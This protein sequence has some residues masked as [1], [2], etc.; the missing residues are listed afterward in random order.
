MPIFSLVRQH[1]DDFLTELSESLRSG[2]YE[3]D[4]LLSFGIPKGTSGEVRTLHIPSIRDRVVER[5]VVNAITHRADLA[6]SPCSFAYRT[7]IGT[8]DAVDHLA[9]LRDA[10][11]RYV[12]RTDIEDYFPNLSIEDALAALS[13]IAGC[14]R[15]IDLIRLIARP[16]RARGER[17]TRNRGIAQGSC[18]SPLLANLALTDVDRAMGDAGYGYARFADDIV[19]CSPHEPDLLEALELLDSLLTPRGLRLNQEKTAMTSFDEGFCYLG[20]DFSRSFPPVDPRHDIKGRPDPDQVVYVGR[21]G[22]RVHVSQNRLIVDGAD[23]LPQV[24]IPRRSVSRIVLTGA[25]GLSSGARSWALYNDIDVIFLSRHGGYLGQLAGPRSTASARR[26]LTQA[27]FATDD[28]AR[29]PL[30][31]AIVRAKM[32]HQVSVLHRTGRRSR[33]SGVETPC[34]TIRQLADDAKQAADVDE[35]MGLEGAASTAYFGCL[36]GLVPP[37]VAFDGRS[38][39]PPKD[40]ANAALSYAYAILLAEC[41]GALLA[42]GLEPS[43]GVLHAS[44]DKH[45]SLSLDLNAAGPPGHH[46]GGVGLPAPGV[47]YPAAAGARRA[48]R[49]AP[50]GHRYHQP[51]RRRHPPQPAVR[52]L[53]DT[54]RGPRNR[55]RARRR[56]T[57]PRSVVSR[58]HAEYARLTSASRPVRRRPRLVRRSVP[59][60]VVMSVAV[61]VAL[62]SVIMM[63]TTVITPR[64]RNL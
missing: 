21:D 60:A 26:L 33:G 48:R 14:P 5:A 58:R 19:I 2:T 31:R 38:R 3:P 10:G 23:G 28:D 64:L 11:Y 50:A 52:L 16:R 49:G 20:T 6:M 37:E 41:T 24:S 4:P 13:P 61:M 27:S 1:L 30:A 57:V 45:P 8:D 15:T 32:R 9:R 55:A 7:G 42:A 40:L 54:Q 47:R 25:V 36:S 39:R 35:L 46:A 29:L 22:A 53:P 18:L 56:R 12:L 59:P 51:G 62:T 44:T 34:T 63:L 17:R 43:L